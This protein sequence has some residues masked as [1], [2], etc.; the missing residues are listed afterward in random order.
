MKRL[1]M[2]AASLALVAAACG[3]GGGNNNAAVDP[4]TCPVDALDNA[5]GPVELVMWETFTGQPLRTMQQLVQEY[6]ASQ[7]KVVVRMEN[8]GVGYEEIQRKFNTAISNRSLG[9]LVVLED[10]QTQFMADSGVIV[11]AEA[12]AEADDYDL[13]QFESVVRSFY[14]VDGALQPAASNLST[15]IMYYNRDHMIAAGLDPDDPPGTLDEVRTVS[16]AIKAANIPGLQQPFVLV[17]QP[18]FIEHWLTGDGVSIVNNNNGRDGMATEGDFNNPT[19]AKLYAWLQGMYNDGLMK[20][21]PGTEGQVDHYFAMAL[22][23]SSM[24]VETSTA[25]STINAVLEGTLD[26][27]EVGLSGDAPIQVNFEVDVAPYP[28]LAGDGSVNAIGTSEPGSVQAGGGAFYIP[29]TNSPEV[30]AAAWDFMKWFNLPATQ[31][32]WMPGS[33]YIAWNTNAYDESS[34]SQWQESTRPGRWLSVA[35]EEIE[36]LDAN[37]PGPLIGPYTEVR[38]AIRQ[39]LDELLLGGQSPENVIAKANETI[40]TALKRYNDENF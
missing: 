2:I 24:T 32:K 29:N 8:Q 16:E 19:T 9:G 1:L 34:L 11:S 22:Q 38:S 39:S 13:D 6:N 4:G 18:W 35:V 20:A 28:G 5:T 15:G 7:D 23:Q 40:T 17:L 37:F 36:G 14:S 30:I 26:P 10:T 27:A 33:T 25:I 3:G 31:A 12:C 21:V